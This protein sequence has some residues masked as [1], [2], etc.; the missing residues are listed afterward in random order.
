MTAPAVEAP[1]PVPGRRPL[2]R[3]GVSGVW[4]GRLVLVTA[5]GL[6]ALVLVAAL[7]TGRGD[8]A[9]PVGDV[10]SVL[11]GG[12]ERA[13]RFVVLEL[14]LPRTFVG[15]L[16]G[17]ALALSGAITQTAS[18]NAL[19]SPDLLGVTEGASAAAVVFIVLGSG[20]A[21][22]GAA[23]SPVGVPLA[24]LAGGVAMALLMYGLAWRRGID[25]YRLIL[26]GVGLGAV[27]EAITSWMLVRAN[28]QEAGRAV[29]WLVGSLNARGWEHVVP[30]GIALAVL[31]PVALLLGFGLGVLQLGDDAARGLGLRVDLTR[32]LL[33]LVAFALAA[34]ATAS[35]GPI[36]FVALVVPQICLRL[37]RSARPPLLTSAVYGALLLVGSDLVTRTL[38]PTEL[39][40]GLVT[41]AIGAPYLIWLL[42]RG[43]T[44]SRS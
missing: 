4:R 9:I 8:F 40:V 18:R 11:A 2:R 37:T 44:A 39:P 41:A 32:S 19:A 42:V 7:N 30:V 23:S 28:V 5:V 10:L 29:A 26:V 22:A 12:G 1:R 24:A 13:Q 25:G 3:R 35:A 34:V 14:R 15:V 33:L 31:V 6:V 36:G 16:V 43:D 20:A 17:A 38:L 27:A 21:A